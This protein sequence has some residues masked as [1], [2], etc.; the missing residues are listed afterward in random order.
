MACPNGTVVEWALDGCT[1]LIKGA[2]GVV[3]QWIV[4]SERQDI[5]VFLDGLTGDDGEFIVEYEGD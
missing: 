4:I 1:L 3:A 5:D 2:P